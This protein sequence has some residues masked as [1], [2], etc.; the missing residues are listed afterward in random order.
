MISKRI[1]F[2]NKKPRQSPLHHDDLPTSTNKSHLCSTHLKTSTDLYS[3]IYRLPLREILQQR[4]DDDNSTS[5]KKE[6]PRQPVEITSNSNLKIKNAMH[7][8]SRKISIH[9]QQQESARELRTDRSSREFAGGRTYELKRI[10]TEL[11]NI[12]GEVCVKNEL[13]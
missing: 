8:S 4:R 9:Q 11:D 6:R 10:R 12:G 13:L 1:S 2:S 3:N 5:L 7:K